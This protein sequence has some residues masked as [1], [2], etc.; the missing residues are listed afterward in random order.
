VT[1]LLILAALFA[2]SDDRPVNRQDQAKASVVMV[3]TLPPQDRERPK[4]RTTEKEK[5]PD[6]RPNPIRDRKDL[7][8]GILVDAGDKDHLYVITVAH[9]ITSK[10]EIWVHAR[11]E[12]QAI[13][14]VRCPV[15]HYDLTRDLAILTLTRERELETS[16]IQLDQVETDMKSIRTLSK[17]EDKERRGVV[18]IGHIQGD[19]AK[20]GGLSWS[21]LPGYL[22][23]VRSSDLAF[24]TIFREEDYARLDRDIKGKDCIQVVLPGGDHGMSGGPIYLANYSKILGLIWMGTRYEGTQSNILCIPGAWIN[25]LPLNKAA[26]WQV[27]KEFAKQGSTPKLSSA[28]PIKTVAG[29]V[30]SF[31]VLPIPTGTSVRCYIDVD[32][33]FAKFNRETLDTKVLYKGREWWDVTHIPTGFTLAIPRDYRL[34]ERLEQLQFG[35]SGPIPVVTLTATGENGDTVKTHIYPYVKGPRGS[36]YQKLLSE[37]VRYRRNILGLGL[38][39]TD[40]NDGGFRPNAVD[41]FCTFADKKFVNRFDFSVGSDDIRMWRMYV[42]CNKNGQPTGT[43]TLSVIGI[44]GDKV[45]ATTTTFATGDWKP[46]APREFATRFFTLA[47]YSFVD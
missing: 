10:D 37:V 16:A 4:V 2:R 6:L 26:N 35:G 46:D 33:L 42:H 13:R 39:D 40:D 5:G 8:T 25:E 18:G 21:P 34:T 30:K 24:R 17:M 9:V 47:T 19:G 43:S 12:N 31:V 29:N 27:P 45:V 20:G 3:T 14:S 23:D 44:R 28:A 7:A 38:L 22:I 41:K 1:A 15:V 11:S 36:L 32:Y